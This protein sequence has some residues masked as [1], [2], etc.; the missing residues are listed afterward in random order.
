[1]SSLPEASFTTFAV[2]GFASTTA[3][4]P[5]P[6]LWT[7]VVSQAPRRDK[8]DVRHYINM[9]FKGRITLAAF[10]THGG[11]VSPASVTLRPGATTQM[12][13]HPDPLVN[14]G[15]TTITLHVHA[16]NMAPL[17]AGSASS[18]STATDASAMTAAPVETTATI[19][20]VLTTDIAIRRG[21]G[22][23]SG[24]FTGGVGT[25]GFG[26]EYR[27]YTFKVPADASNVQVSVRWL[28]RANLFLLGLIDPNGKIVNVVDNSLRNADGTPDLTHPSAE[29][30]LNHPIPGTWRIAFMTLITAGVYPN[31]PFQGIVVINQQPAQLSSASVSTH[32]GGSPAAFTVKVK[33][34]GVGI[35]AYYS[36]T[37]TDQ[38]A[39]LALGGT[40]GTLQNGTALGVGATQ[41][42]TYTTSFVPPGTREV[43]SQAQGLNN[44]SPI[45]VELDDSQFASYRAFAQQS[46]VALSGQVGNGYSAVIRGKSLPIGQYF[47]QV[48]LPT[49]KSTKQVY[50]AASTQ[51]YALSPQPWIKMDA[52]RAVDGTLNQSLLVALPTGSVTFHGRVSVPSTVAPGTYHAHIFIYNFRDDQVAD[53][54]L[55]VNVLPA[56]PEPAATPDPLL[57]TIAST[58]YFPEGATA[59]GLLDQ[60][61]LVNPGSS[62]AHVQVR[63][64]TEGGWTTVTRYALPAHSR[65]SVNVQPL[66]GIDQA[67]AAIVQADQTVVSGR[68][69]LRQGEAG[70]Y[71]VGTVAP[72]KTWYFADGYTV[73][74]FQEFLTVVNPGAQVAHLHIHLV[75]DQGGSQDGNLTVNGSSRR[76]IQVADLMPGKAVSA[77]ITSDVPVVAERLQEFGNLG[78]GVTT[79]IGATAAS[80]ALYIDP[81]HLPKGTQGHIT[82]YNPGS[83]PATVTLAMINGNGKTMRTLKVQIMARHRT[84][85][86]LT[87]RYG[88]AGLG[89]LITSDAPVVAE[90]VAYFG[91]VR[92]G[93]VGGSDLAGQATPTSHVV[94]PGGTT[95]NGAVD[96]LNLYN[97]GAFDAS[98]VVTAVYDGNHTLQRTVQI[99]A[100][101][102]K[103]IDVS[104]L[105]LP[106]G[107]SSLIVDG[108]GGAQFYATQSTFN[109]A[110]TDG[111]EISGIV[112][113]GQ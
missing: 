13:F 86:D 49:G 69:I 34:T 96:Y 32:A 2:S 60:M 111:S 54:P 84:N 72:G 110:G 81:G 101:Q 57:A 18:T 64:L 106:S 20:V 46:Q 95:A 104:S 82:V 16:R 48:S 85:V 98:I 53:L 80:K 88:T 51:A 42:L 36:Y 91:K 11:L 21:V 90:K 29:T 9:P 87:A 4:H 78:Q 27:Y 73:G 61:D 12:V 7:A 22:N 71:S 44:V 3:A 8:H 66:V 113:S 30:F 45:D 77:S 6:G 40:G 35:D 68:L 41:T 10:Q 23:F 103:S 79:T 52:Q 97:P 109:K 105:G 92:K 65:K 5:A 58:Q 83:T 108:S 89:A 100:Q 17:P 94:F 43:I 67:I 33:N 50:V 25:Q 59:S 112:T 47:V 1:Q 31:E 37:T 102:R 70:S 39:Y 26:R 14:P 75:S 55:T 19:P 28:H 107:A 63:L 24:V 56:G 38:Y 76:T 93:T 99:P 62:L 15:V 74:N